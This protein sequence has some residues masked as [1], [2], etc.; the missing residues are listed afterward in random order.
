[1]HAH[2]SSKPALMLIK[3]LLFM[4]LS[5]L[6]VKACLCCY[7]VN[8]SVSLCRVSVEVLDLYQGCFM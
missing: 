3:L 6:C 1:M 4:I 2:S 5:A 7:K 8:D